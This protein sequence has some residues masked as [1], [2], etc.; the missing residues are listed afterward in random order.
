MNEER[1]EKC[2]REVKHIYGKSPKPD[3]DN[4]SSIAIL[5]L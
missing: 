4:E 2:L 1:T 3:I 5:D